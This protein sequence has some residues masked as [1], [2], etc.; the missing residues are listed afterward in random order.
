MGGDEGLTPAGVGGEAG[1]GDAGRRGGSGAAVYWVYV[2][3]CGYEGLTTARVSGEVGFCCALTVFWVR[4]CGLAAGVLLDIFV[5]G[6]EGLGSAN[7]CLQ[8]C[9]GD[10]CKAGG[11][12]AGPRIRWIR[13]R[14]KSIEDAVTD[15]GTFL[16]FA[17]S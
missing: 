10:G 1:C 2:S 16:G 12:R 8:A 15:R 13:A 14:Q 7:V 11:E 6:D 17:L 9:C 3:L 5:G 4:I